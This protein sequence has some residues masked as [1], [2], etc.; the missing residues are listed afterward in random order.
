MRVLLQRTR[1]AAVKAADQSKVEIGPGVMGLVGF[2]T[3][4]EHLPGTRTW[5]VMV[6]KILRLRIFPDDKGLM[7][8]SL[9][10][11]NGELLLVPQFTLYA[12]CSKG[13]RPGFSGSAPGNVAERLFD[14][15]AEKVLQNWTRVSFGYFGAEMDVELCNWGPV[16]IMLDSSDYLQK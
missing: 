4:D 16:T 14:R 5:N 12:D 6:D 1:W 7:N 9:M 11:V 3:E 10:D 15:F 13:R 2:A 8:L